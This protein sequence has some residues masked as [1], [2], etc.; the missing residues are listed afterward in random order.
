MNQCVSFNDAEKSTDVTQDNDLNI[1]NLKD[2]L[3]TFVSNTE[4]LLD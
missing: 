4:N 1:E 2:D 3:V